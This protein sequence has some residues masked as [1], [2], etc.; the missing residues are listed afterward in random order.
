MRA[1]QTRIVTLLGSAGIGKSR[2]IQDFILR[3]RERG[4]AAPVKVYRGSARDSG[5]LV[6]GVRAA[7]ARALR[8]G[9]GH[10]RRGR[11]GAGPRPGR[12]GARRPQGRRRRA[13]SSV[14][15]S[16]LPFEESPLTRAVSDDRAASAAPAPRDLQGVP[17]G[18]RRARRRCA[19]C[20]EDLHHAHE[21]SLELLR[22][23]LE[24]LIG[25]HPGDLRGA[26]RAADAPRGLGPRRRG[27]PRADRARR[28]RDADAASDDGSAARAL[29]AASVA[30]AARRARV[31]ASPAATRCCSSRWCASTTTRACSKRR[32]AVS[33]EPRVAGRPRQARHALGC[34]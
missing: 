18:R 24:N 29:P 32:R 16:I 11:E 12:H 3:Q 9:R 17:R 25:P 13:T 34:R 31:R 21:D 15:C 10:G 8:P 27:A 2:L 30:G 19:S 7:L 4:G 5:D 6:R 33:D 22:Y 28:S 14:S 1:G 23:L 26:A 20:F